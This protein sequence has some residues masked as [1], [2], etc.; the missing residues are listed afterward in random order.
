[1]TRV[2]YF[3]DSFHEVNGVALTSRML[4]RY[5][6]ERGNPFL[7]VHTGP[8]TRCW[9]LGS[10]RRVELALGRWSLWLEQDL[11][12]DVHYARHKPLL[13]EELAS[14]RP[15]V[16]HVTG[17]SHLGLLGLWASR[18][19]RVP[20][21]ASWHTNVHEYAR[22]RLRQYLARLPRGVATS[23]GRS[24]EALTLA[25]TLRFYKFAQRTLAPN[26]E[27]TAML[28]AGA[29]H[30]ST[31]MKRGVDTELYHPRKRRRADDVVRIGFAGRLS[32]EKG[33]RWLRTVEEELERQGVT[34]YEFWIAGHGRE[35][36]WLRHNLWHR[37]ITGVL[38]GEELA[39]FYANLDLF[40]FPSET[41]TY[42]NAIQEAM[43]SGV[44]C[45]VTSCGGPKYLVRQ[46]V[47]G[48]IASGEQAFAQ[49]CARL[50]REDD[51][52]TCMA[53]RARQAAE[54]ATWERVF[55]G[56]YRVY[57]ECASLSAA[58]AA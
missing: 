30:P 40:A 32:P 57:A 10:A 44:P 12:F 35:E 6:C 16:I 55:D 58:T 34:N 36:Q 21:V 33:V 49:A 26:P 1:M 18:R 8:Q 52:R 5:A 19:L 47:D 4:E 38:R 22:R 56:V 54:A 9:D 20:L 14:F 41:D 28:E 42:G 24:A 13:L 7:S 39:E 46:E 2:A 53:R 50:A 27:L 37:Q 45:V 31:L 11:R 51:T 3:A 23:A 48:L 25:A 15:D 43:A 29:G 17:P